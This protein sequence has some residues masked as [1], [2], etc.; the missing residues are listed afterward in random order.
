MNEIIE[1][2]IADKDILEE[3][4]N[5]YDFKMPDNLRKEG[6]RLPDFLFP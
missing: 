4:I 3:T 1:F 2:T 6:W 5:L